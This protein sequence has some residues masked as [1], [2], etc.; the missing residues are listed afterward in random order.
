M[1]LPTELGIL[2]LLG[3]TNITRLRRSDNEGKNTQFCGLI[4]GSSRLSQSFGAVKSV[5]RGVSIG[6]NGFALSAH[7]FMERIPTK[8]VKGPFGAKMKSTPPKKIRCLF[9]RFLDVYNG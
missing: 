9:F 5:L 2:F 7:P 8:N 3:S 1:T 4:L 6:Y